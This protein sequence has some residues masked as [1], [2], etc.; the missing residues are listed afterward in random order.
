VTDSLAKQLL[1]VTYSHSKQQAHL[2]FSEEHTNVA[3]FEHTFEHAEGDFDSYQLEARIAYNDKREQPW[4]LSIHGAR[5]DF[6]KSDAVTI[7]LQQKGYS[8]LGMNLSGHSPAGVLASEQTT[9]SNNIGEVAAFY[10]YLSPHRQK[11]VIG[12][13]M[14]GTSALKLLE[15]HADEIDKLIL[16]YPGIYSRESY[17][18]HFGTDFRTVI[19]EPYSYR[20]NDVIALLEKFKGKLLLIKGQYDGLDPTKYGKPAGTSVGEV[21]IDGITRYSPI[22]KDVI[23]MIYGA[24]PSTQKSLIEVPDCDHSIV[25]WM[26]QPQ[27]HTLAARLLDKIDAFIKS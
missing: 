7:G 22:P 9:L 19:A 18:K 1:P 17:N 20:Q 24:L 26:R 4:V 27:N 5:A 23:D 15:E 2:Y 25:L 8:I 13:S 14:G 21:E 3:Y 10:Q 6:T 16:F 12:Y 11:V